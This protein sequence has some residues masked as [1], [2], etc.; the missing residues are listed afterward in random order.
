[1]NLGKEGNESRPRFQISPGYIASW[2]GGG[3]PI[4]V[5]SQPDSFYSD[6]EQELDEHA[7]VGRT[8]SPQ[9]SC[10]SFSAAMDGS[11]KDT[12]VPVATN[13]FHMDPSDECNGAAVTTAATTP[14]FATKRGEKEE[15]GEE[16]ESEEEEL[17]GPNDYCREHLKV[18]CISTVNDE[19]NEM[20]SPKLIVSPYDSDHPHQHNSKSNWAE[21]DKLPEEDDTAPV[22]TLENK[23][24]ENKQQRHGSLHSGHDGIS[25]PSAAQEG[26]RRRGK[27]RS[28]Q[29][30]SKSS[31]KHTAEGKSLCHH[32]TSS[33]DSP[34]SIAKEKILSSSSSSR[35]QTTL[36]HKPEEEEKER[37]SDSCFRCKRV[38][39][40]RCTIHMYRDMSFCSKECRHGQIKCD[41]YVKCLRDT[42]EQTFKGT[43]LPIIEATSLR[44]R[45]RA[46][47]SPIDIP[48]ISA[49]HLT[50]ATNDVIGKVGSPPISSSISGGR[51]TAESY[52]NSCTKPLTSK[53]STETRERYGT[54]EV[55]C[56]AHV[57]SYTGTRFMKS[58][59]F[60]TLL[61]SVDEKNGISERHA[62]HSP[63][64][65]DVVAGLIQWQVDPSRCRH[66][67]LQ[68]TP[69]LMCW[70]S[71]TEVEVMACF[72]CYGLGSVWNGKV[73]INPIMKIRDAIKFDSIN[74][75]RQRVRRDQEIARRLWEAVEMRELHP[76]LGSNCYSYNTCVSSCSVGP[77]LDEICFDSDSDG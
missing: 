20:P 74:A 29:T 41:E 53:E 62:L 40:G 2:I 49:D 61:L 54:S 28:Q 55:F 32:E 75:L 7:R 17:L 56:S 60:E 45:T 46:S 33:S 51:N 38:L 57:V 21:A 3:T 69:V 71:R 24:K 18:G 64:P 66:T 73:L 77:C 23:K 19:G 10:E 58:L 52:A 11:L 39:K 37:D 47:S 4:T 76:Q 70:A 35:P 30:S 44:T 50:T 67:S 16:E 59:G 5:T 8:I 9:S 1:M 22:L 63:R 12:S 43:Y 26:Q 42:I 13:N 15:E 25:S 72:E 6:E 36:Q 14:L 68:T 65:G 31:Q 48:C 27:W 34:C